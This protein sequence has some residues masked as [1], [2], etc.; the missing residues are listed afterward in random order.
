LA[1][2]PKVQFIFVG[3]IEDKLYFHKII[4][5]IELRNLSGF[6]MFTG[7][8]PRKELNALYNK[9]TIFAFP[10]IAETQG[11]VLLEAMSYGLPI[12]ASK[13]GP[14]MDIVC[15]F[16]HS[17]LLV[18]QDSESLAESINKLLDDNA[19]R[20]ELSQ[21]ARKVASVF[22]WNAVASRVLVLYGQLTV[23]RK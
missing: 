13:I 18:N 8:I 14:I 10:T 19:L 2:H 21:N 9:A 16:P 12:V 23:N 7:E 1:A 5:L 3:P 4:E 20:F 15:R 17:A 6:V 11:I 22:S